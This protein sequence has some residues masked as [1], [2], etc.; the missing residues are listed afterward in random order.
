VKFL[1]A[2]EHGCVLVT[3]DRDDF[4]GLASQQPYHCIIVIVRRRSRAAERVAL[5]RL[6]E[7]A[8]ETGLEN[9]INFA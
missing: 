2:H 4:I 1:F 3:C 5:F 8:G 7:R 6:P 9:N